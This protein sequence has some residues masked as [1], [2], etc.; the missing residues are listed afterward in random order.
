MHR[1]FTQS[2]TEYW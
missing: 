1:V 2:C